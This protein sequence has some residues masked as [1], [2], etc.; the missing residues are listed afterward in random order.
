MTESEQV[1]NAVSFDL[2]HWRSATLLSGEV[3]DP[4]DRIGSSIDGVLD[5]FRRCDTRSEIAAEYTE[6]CNPDVRV[7]PVP[8]HQ[9][10]ASVYERKRPRG[11]VEGFPSPFEFASVRDVIR[12]R[13]GSRLESDDAGNRTTKIDPGQSHG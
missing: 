4:K 11:K 1:T 7:D 3:D 8:L 2:E 5:T 12:A 10:F 6:N 13:I 9:R